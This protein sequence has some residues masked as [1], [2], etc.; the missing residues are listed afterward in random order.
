MGGARGARVLLPRMVLRGD[1]GPGRQS[2][3]VLMGRCEVGI[4]GSRVA[5]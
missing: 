2:L 5:F 4:D 3:G 1:D